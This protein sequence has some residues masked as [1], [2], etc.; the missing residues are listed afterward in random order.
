MKKRNDLSSRSPPLIAVGNRHPV[1][2]HDAHRQSDW[3]K[4]DKY[5]YYSASDFAA[6]NK[7]ANE[8]RPLHGPMT[9]ADERIGS[10]AT[11]ARNLLENKTDCA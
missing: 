9:E 3:E 5:W 11:H 7:A 6:K 10:D 4:P 8:P 1:P 2:S